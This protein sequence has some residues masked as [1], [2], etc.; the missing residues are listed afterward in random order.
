MKIIELIGQSRKMK[1]NTN[2]L[3]ELQYLVSQRDYTESLPIKI[4]VR[5][6][7][8]NKKAKKMGELYKINLF[9]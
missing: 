6:Y 7:E 1:E 4:T 2:L 9:S 3:K 5:F 8:L